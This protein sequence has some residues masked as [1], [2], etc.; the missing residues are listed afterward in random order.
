MEKL[1]QSFQQTLPTGPAFDMTLVEGG[2]FIMG[3]EDSAAFDREKPLHKVRLDSF[4]MGKYLV[5]Q[6][7]WLA[8]MTGENPSS[9]KGENRPVEQVSW[10]DAQA[11][12]QKLNEQTGRNYRLPTEAEWEYAARGGIYSAGFL[13][14][15]S[16]KLKEGGGM[17]KTAAG[18]LMR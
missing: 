7:Q 14:A 9:F 10:D 12:I 15:G 1:V 8:V 4:Y 6:A 13:Y 3:G 17:Q 5:T 16:D 11:F 18:K 2:T